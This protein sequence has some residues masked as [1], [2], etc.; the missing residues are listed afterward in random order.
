MVLSNRAQQAAR[1]TDRV[2]LR[3]RSGSRP[4][5]RATA[6]ASRCTRTSSASGSSAAYQATPPA[7][8]TSAGR[9]RPARVP[10]SHTT[11]PGAGHRDRTVPV[12]H[13]RVGL[14]PHP[15]RLAQS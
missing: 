10:S 14:G 2:R 5:A 13:G 15:G 8:A 6:A 9:A 7:A 3:G 4:R 1:M 11:L 12:F